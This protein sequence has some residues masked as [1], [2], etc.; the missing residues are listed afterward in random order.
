M[1]NSPLLR[2]Q[3]L[4]SRKMEATG[5][6]EEKGIS[7]ALQYITKPVSPHRLLRAIRDIPDGK[8]GDDLERS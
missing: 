3:L 6:L 2:E 4:Q 8:R 7:A 5:T 1:D